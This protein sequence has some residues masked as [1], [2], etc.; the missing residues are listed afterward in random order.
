[1]R[2]LA[3]S[4]AA[5]LEGGTTRLA[6]AIRLTRRDGQVFGLTDHDAALSFAGT[7]FQP[8][9][10]FEASEESTALGPVAGEWDLRAALSDDS[11]TMGDLLAGAFDGAQVESFLVDWSDAASHHLLSCGTLGQITA[12]D[13]LFQCEVRGPFAAYDRVRRRVFA[14]RCDAELGDARC[15]VDLADQAFSVSAGL[16][17]LL[18]P[19]LLAFDHL[20]SYPPGHF[21]G[22]LARLGL[23][24]AIGIR[25][26]RVEGARTL[27]ELW[28]TPGSPPVTGTMTLLQ[29]GCDK[30]FATCTARF[31][32]GVNFRGFPF[33]P[34]DDF[35]LSYP[36][37]GQGD[38]DGGSL[39]GGGA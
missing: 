38:L 4:L 1:M 5:S 33:M 30:R 37:A 34:G 19:N 17:A 26:H 6:R 8:A 16:S 28:Q 36:A 23:H 13:G 24:E 29:A 27:I 21:D 39:A 15:G 35:A 20:G 14:S 11:L 18:Q 22:G 32:N 2:D 3:P 7:V 25:A 12:R 31:A 10:G 9:D